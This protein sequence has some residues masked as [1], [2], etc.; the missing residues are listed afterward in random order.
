MRD[1]PQMMSENISNDVVFL[2]SD[3]EDG[4]IRG[5]HVCLTHLD[6]Y[7]Y[8]GRLTRSIQTHISMCINVEP[9]SAI[10]MT[11]THNHEVHL[12]PM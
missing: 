4:R 2:A 12:D 9:A 10:A 7:F 3:T 1:E 8:N 6:F 5:A 11:N